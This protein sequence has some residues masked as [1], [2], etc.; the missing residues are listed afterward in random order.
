MPYLPIFFRN[1]LTRIASIFNCYPVTTRIGLSI[2]APM[3]QTKQQSTFVW[4][5]LIEKPL[6]KQENKH[7]QIKIQIQKLPPRTYYLEGSKTLIL[8]GL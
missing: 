7:L 8:Y 6:C 1:F 5:D 2:K 3:L 4:Y